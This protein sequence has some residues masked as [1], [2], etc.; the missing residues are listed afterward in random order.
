MYPEPWGLLVLDKPEGL[1]SHTAV[2]RVRR[3][4]GA[5]RAGHAGTLDPLATGVLLVGL[6]RATRLLEYLV[7]HDKEYRARIRLGER[8]DTLDREGRLLETLPVPSLSPRLI[9]EALAR[10]RGAF[11][12]IPPVYSAV[13]VQ[14]VSLHRRARRGEA[15]EPPPRTVEI[16]ELELVGIEGPDVLLRIA[17]SS[18]TYVRSLARDLGS[19]LG[20]AAALWELTR[21]RSGPFGLG[22]ARS[23]AEVVAAGPE[24][25]PWVLPAERMADGL[26]ACAISA[27][28]AREIA[29]GRALHRV[30]EGEGGPIALF[31]PGGTLVAVARPQGGC[32]QPVKVFDGAG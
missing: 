18:G 11:V 16:H 21:I 14:G 26:P 12:Q 32:L 4:L 25:W 24:A 7:G 3:S 8:R 20:T 2:Q 9:E 1:T 27:E 29:Q 10:F 13:K 31:G 17:C 30:P 5:S 23:L 28:E 22:D 19:A 6:G 15:V